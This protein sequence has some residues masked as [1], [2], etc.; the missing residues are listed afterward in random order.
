MTWCYRSPTPTKANEIG[1]A[2]EAC[3]LADQY[4]DTRGRASPFGAN[5]AGRLQS[6]KHQSRAMALTVPCPST[7]PLPPPAGS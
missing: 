5:A 1:D 2:V 3:G 7:L 6:P 4:P